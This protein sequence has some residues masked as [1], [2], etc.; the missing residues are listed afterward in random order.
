MG[1]IPVGG[2][3]KFF[4]RVIRLENASSLFST[5]QSIKPGCQFIAKEFNY[6][7]GRLEIIHSSL[8]RN[9]LR[10]VNSSFLSFFNSINLSVLLSVC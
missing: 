8:L 4:F 9:Y 3:G 7:I 2:L 6:N 5:S 10:E 1:S